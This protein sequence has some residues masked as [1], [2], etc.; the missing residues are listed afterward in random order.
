MSAPRESNM[1]QTYV[2]LE[3]GQH[4]DL[5]KQAIPECLIRAAPD[6]RNALKHTQPRFPDWYAK[7]TSAQ[8]AQI[9]PLIKAVCESQNTLDKTLSSLQSAEAFGQKLLEA[10]LEKIGFALPVNDVH[11]RLYVPVGN[12]IS[13]VTG[14]KVQTFS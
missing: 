4:Y 7:A 3:Q 10:E 12:I 13:G 6:R 1:F 2:P 9:K 8:R 5:I 14:H 11:L